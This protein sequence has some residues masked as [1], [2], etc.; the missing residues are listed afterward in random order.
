MIEFM[1]YLFCWLKKC[2]IHTW[3]YAYAACKKCI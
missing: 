3:R 1:Q 2:N